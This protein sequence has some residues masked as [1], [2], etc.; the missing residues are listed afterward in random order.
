MLT[1]KEGNVE[2]L[3]GGIGNYNTERYVSRFFKELTGLKPTDIVVHYFLRDAESCPPAAA[4][5]S[6]DT[7]NSRSRFGSPIIAFSTNTARQRW[8]STTA[9]SMIRRR[10]GFQVMQVQAARARRLCEAQ[11]HRL[12]L[13]MV[14]DV[15]N[16]NDYKFGFVH[17]TMR[18]IADSH[19]YR[20]CGSAARDARP[21][22]RSKTLGDA[23]RSPS[24]CVRT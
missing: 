11:Q 6:C 2:V 1:A 24:E 10:P 8:S 13:A 7:A 3:N 21:A 19:G 15:H 5:S 20:L 22:R 17:E 23:W 9:R 18:K 12:Y 14:P 16:L 4:I